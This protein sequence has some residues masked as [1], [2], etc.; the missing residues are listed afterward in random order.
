MI[1]CSAMAALLLAT[2]Y[3]PLFHVHA[4]E[5]G[6]APLVHAH[7][8]ELENA[9]S[10]RVVHMEA[11]HTSTFL[12]MIVIPALYLRYS[13]AEAHVDRAIL[14]KNSEILQHPSQIA[15]L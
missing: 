3:A 7:F 12:N 5:A 8:P 9:E 10:E 15:D 11:H 2:V 14:T 4:D 6:E 13:R 1:A